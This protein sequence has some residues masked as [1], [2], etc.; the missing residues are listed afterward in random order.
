MMYCFI[1]AVATLKRGDATL[2]LS[3]SGGSYSGSGN[4]VKD[5]ALLILTN[6]GNIYE[7]VLFL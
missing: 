3:G 6:N 1:I 4:I 7:R 5:A 2:T